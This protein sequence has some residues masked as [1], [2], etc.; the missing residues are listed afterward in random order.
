M[1]EPFASNSFYYIEMRTFE[2]NCKFSNKNDL[3][4]AYGDFK[5]IL[6]GIYD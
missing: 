1:W 5:K 6:C 3:L 2:K 4:S